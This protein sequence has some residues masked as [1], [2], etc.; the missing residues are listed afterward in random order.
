MSHVSED[1]LIIPYLFRKIKY[2]ISKNVTDSIFL[3]SVL[4][5]TRKGVQLYDVR[6]QD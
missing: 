6:Y 5:N 1:E 4:K 3:V 2:K